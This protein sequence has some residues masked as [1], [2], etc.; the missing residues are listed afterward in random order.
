MNEVHEQARL[1]Q[2]RQQELQQGMEQMR[3][4]KE[5]VGL[6]AGQAAGRHREAKQALEA[7]QSQVGRWG[8]RWGDQPSMPPP[9]L[10]HLTS[11]HPTT[12]T[13]HHPTSAPPPTV[14]HPTAPRIEL[15]MRGAL[16]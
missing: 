11:D 3:S 2:E 8:Y 15:C 4:A 9:P 1:V 10:C 12:K 7:A 14:V 5:Q 16:N 6:E 13:I